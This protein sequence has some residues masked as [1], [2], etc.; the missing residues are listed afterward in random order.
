[1]GLI[2]G[3][4]GVPLGEWMRDTDIRK[5]YSLANLSYSRANAALRT[6]DFK[7]ALSLAANLPAG[8]SERNELA[9]PIFQAALD[10]HDFDVALSASELEAKTSRL[11]ISRPGD[12]NWGAFYVV[13]DLRSRLAKA[14]LA[15]RGFEGARRF[16]LEKKNPAQDDMILAL[17]AETHPAEVVAIFKSLPPERQE[18]LT[19]AIALAYIGD[20]EVSEALE[21]LQSVSAHGGP[22]VLSLILGLFPSMGRESLLEAVVFRKPLRPTW[23]SKELVRAA[24]TDPDVMPL[25]L[26]QFLAL[27][28]V[29]RSEKE[30]QLKMLRKAASKDKDRQAAIVHDAVVQGIYLQVSSAGER[31]LW[32]DRFLDPALRRGK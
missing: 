6:G 9:F 30:R 12:R 7:R 22:D 1:M 29:T 26:R 5:S 19:G 18:K 24:S 32:R 16:A 14:L 20:K 3:L 21:P 27:P 10:H 11:G 2:P 8:S 4:T 15:E 13:G 25:T 23:F 28:N 31:K 17:G